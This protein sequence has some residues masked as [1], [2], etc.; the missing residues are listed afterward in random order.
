MKTMADLA[1]QNGNGFDDSCGSSS[2]F[3]SSTSSS[4]LKA[5]Q[6]CWENT[7]EEEKKKQHGQ[8]LDV[9][10]A[11]AHKKNS[12]YVQQE[13][14]LSVVT[15]EG[16]ENTIARSRT[17]S[18]KLENV[19][20]GC[21]R[22]NYQGRKDCSQSFPFSLSIFFTAI[23]LMVCVMS[24]VV[25]GSFNDELELE[26][27]TVFDNVVVNVEDVVNA[28]GVVEIVET[29]T[30]FIEHSQAPLIVPDKISP[31]A[32]HVSIPHDLRSRTVFFKGHG[33]NDVLFPSATVESILDL[34]VL[35]LAQESGVV[36]HGRH[37]LKGFDDGSDIGSD[38]VTPCPTIYTTDAAE[39]AA[40]VTVDAGIRESDVLTKFVRDFFFKIQKKKTRT[41][42][43]QNIFLTFHTVSIPLISFSFNDNRA[44]R[45]L[46]TLYMPVIHL[47]LCLI[48]INRRC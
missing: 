11:A 27:S 41:T 2:S 26:K 13:S 16:S 8:P 12:E 15:G 42:S 36:H 20:S 33:N 21:Q 14:M 28:D 44:Q 43:N 23:I 31:R 4:L 19:I 29:N 30:S 38:I 7:L 24:E 37:L 9:L 18:L 1:T 48:L 45:N 34:D 25:S 47:M 46:M 22:R 39:M 32:E 17:R 3:A 10:T 5:A 6:I 35:A 40:N